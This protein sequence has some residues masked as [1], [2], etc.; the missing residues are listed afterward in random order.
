MRLISFIF[1]IS[2][3]RSLSQFYFYEFN[4]SLSIIILSIKNYNVNFIFMDLCGFN[5]ENDII[6]FLNSL[7]CKNST[8]VFNSGST[9]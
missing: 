6:Y 7:M 1:I 3:V 9:F 8:A 2:F 4:F 5:F